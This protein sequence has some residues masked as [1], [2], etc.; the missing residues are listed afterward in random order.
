MTSSAAMK[1]RYLSVIKPTLFLG[2]ALALVSC[3][4]LTNPLPKCD[5]NA[6][7]PLNRAMW[8]WERSSASPKPDAQAITRF[9]H[10]N[11]QS[12]AFDHFDIDASFG[13]CED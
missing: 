7:R 12:S 3:A 6:R 2:I 9:V 13:D 5:G 1:N 4:S 8:Q 11:K 10:E